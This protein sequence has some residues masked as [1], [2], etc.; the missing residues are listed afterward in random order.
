MTI[1]PDRLF[2]TLQREFTTATGFARIHAAEVLCEHGHGYQVTA[3]M[4]AE[5]ETTEPMYRLGVWRVLARVAK[6]DAERARYVERIRRVMF[7]ESAPDRDGAAESL[8]KLGVADPADRAPI[9]QWLAKADDAASVFPLWLRLLS[10]T[11]AERPADEARLAGYLESKD[12]IARLRASYILGRLPGIS[13]ETITR[14]HRRAENEPADS[15]ARVYLIA[16]SFLRAPR[17]SEWARALKKKL[18]SYIE[19][20][21]GNEQFEVG[22]VLGL[23]GPSTSDLDAFARLLKSPE[24]DGR[25]GGASGMLQFK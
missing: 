7:D 2:D 3:A 20:G 19:T 8:A 12:P 9:D 21:K 11:D 13:V 5:A 25:I 10:D 4:Q 18:L 23:R 6:D 24:A 22:T 17:D 1:L 14:I 15:P 16:A